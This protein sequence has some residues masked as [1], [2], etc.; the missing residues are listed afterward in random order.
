MRGII[1]ILLSLSF[2]SLHFCFSCRVIITFQL[3]VLSS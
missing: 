3:L 1:M 2:F